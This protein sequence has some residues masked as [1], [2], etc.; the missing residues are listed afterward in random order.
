MVRSVLA[1]PHYRT[2]KGGQEAAGEDA[3]AV[4]EGAWGP[5]EGGGTATSPT[6]TQVRNNAG[7]TYQAGSDMKQEINE[8]LAG[9]AR[10]VHGAPGEE[11][12]EDLWALLLETQALTTLACMADATGLAAERTVIPNPDAGERAAMEARGCLA[13]P[14]LTHGLFEDFA[15]RGAWYA[16]LRERGW[17]GFNIVWLD[18]CGT[19]MTAAGRKKQMDI[20]HVFRDQLL[21]P[22]AVFAVTFAVRGSRNMYYDEVADTA[23]KLTTR[24]AAAGGYHGIRPYGQATYCSKRG[25]IHTVAFVNSAD[26]WSRRTRWVPFPPETAK[27]GKVGYIKY[28]SRRRVLLKVWQRWCEGD[29]AA[30]EWME[31]ADWKR[32]TPHCECIIAGARVL[33]DL[34]PERKSAFVLDS[35]LL[36]ATKLLRHR[37]AACFT[38]LEDELHGEPGIP[39]TDIGNKYIVS[40]DEA[41]DAWWLCYVSRKAFNAKVLRKCA[42]W[43]DMQNIMTKRLARSL[44]GIVVPFVTVTEPWLGGAV[45]WMISGH[46]AACAMYNH[47]MLHPLYVCTWVLGT[48]HMIIVFGVGDEY[49]TDEKG[50]LLDPAKRAVVERAAPQE[51]P[52]VKQWTCRFG[53]DFDRKKTPAPHAVRFKKM[54]PDISKALPPGEYGAGGRTVCIYEPGGF[55]VCPVYPTASYTTHDPLEVR[56]MTRR[57]RA[58][59]A[60]DDI[61]ADDLLLLTD[62]GTI[63]FREMWYDAV[64]RWVAAPAAATPRRLLILLEITHQDLYDGLKDDLRAV[65]PA[66]DAALESMHSSECF[67]RKWD[68]LLCTYSPRPPAAPEA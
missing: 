24:L 15:E 52:D 36:P 68:L 13:Y 32:A 43:T 4:P 38:V 39:H 60:A 66:H 33:S 62:E 16:A 7:D 61:A 17:T 67:A 63:P 37:K 11:E 59:A 49:A 1:H 6:L 65:S 41:Y 18:Y 30:W 3:A 56:E 54:L 23:C 29:R 44:I 22:R 2:K 20:M 26:F 21:A 53:W 31:P 14:G 48:P 35:A 57:G 47:P 12:G 27:S 8:W 46:H 45:D 34:L 42:D 10:E 19:L 50:R 64:K 25:I 9:V 5:R 55:Y 51:P 58:V 40:H 28:C